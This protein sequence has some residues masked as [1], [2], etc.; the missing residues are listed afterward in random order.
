M[1][2][3]EKELEKDATCTTSACGSTKQD[4]QQ[5]QAKLEAEK[6]AQAEKKQSGGCCGG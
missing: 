1:A 6:K 2:T 4:Q 3:S 5:L